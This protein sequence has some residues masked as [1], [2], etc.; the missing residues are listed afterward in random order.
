MPTFTLAHWDDIVRDVHDIIRSNHKLGVSDEKND[1][2]QCVGYCHLLSSISFTSVS[3]LTPV[4][5]SGNIVEHNDDMGM[6]ETG[7]P[8]TPG[9]QN[10]ELAHAAGIR[11]GTCRS[12]AG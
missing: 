9:K 4:D 8:S 3:D 5:A 7:T 12:R 2:E 11:L 6:E 1:S 10:V